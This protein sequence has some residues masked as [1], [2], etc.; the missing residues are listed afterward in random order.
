[1]KEFLNDW[2]LSAGGVPAAGGCRR[3]ADRPRKEE[4]AHK[5]IALITSAARS[6][7]DG[8]SSSLTNFDYDRV[9]DPAV[10]RRQGVDPVHQQPLHR[11][12][13]RHLAAAAGADG[14]HRAAVRHLLLEP[15]A[16][17]GQPEGVLHAAPHARDGHGRHVRRTRPHPVLRLLRGRAA[18]DVLHDRRVGRRAAPVRGDQVLPL[19]AVRLGAD[20][21]QLHRAL[22]ALG[23]G[24]VDGR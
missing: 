12:P 19:H 9:R 15:P 20:D 1:M 6:L 23:Q 14:L 16:R 10:R 24:P 17:A 11:R 3:H 5:W 21:R 18:P 22:L 4:D 2:G 8:R 7:R 13:R